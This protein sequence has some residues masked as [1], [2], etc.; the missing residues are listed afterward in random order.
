VRAQVRLRGFLPLVAGKKKKKK[1]KEK[2][3]DLFL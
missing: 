3:L 2:D 1:E